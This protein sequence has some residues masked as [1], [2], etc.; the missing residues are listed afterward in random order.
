MNGHV[1][2]TYIEYNRGEV[3]DTGDDSWLYVAA[4]I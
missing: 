1:P 2:E 4:G 3:A